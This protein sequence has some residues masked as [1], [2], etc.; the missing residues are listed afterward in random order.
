[1]SDYI[2]PILSLNFPN[3][4]LLTNANNPIQKNMIQIRQIC[5]NYDT[6]MS[7]KDTIMIQ[8]CHN[9]IIKRYHYDTNMTDTH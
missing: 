4:G 6:N 8:K 7:Q 9:Y 1:M 2:L 5:H 3:K